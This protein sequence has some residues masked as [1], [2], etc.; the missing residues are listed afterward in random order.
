MA[1]RILNED[2][3]AP[4]ESGGTPSQCVSAALAGLL[5]NPSKKECSLLPVK[6]AG[7]KFTAGGRQ[8]NK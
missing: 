5:V 6:Q 2:T 1:G 8:R 7:S 3:P 4:E